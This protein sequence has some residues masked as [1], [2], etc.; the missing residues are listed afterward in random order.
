[1]LGN[2]AKFV[3]FKNPYESVVNANNLIEI[4]NIKAERGNELIELVKNVVE[5]QDYRVFPIIQEDLLE[6]GWKYPQKY[7]NNN[8]RFQK[9]NYEINK[10]GSKYLR[11]PE[12]FYTI[13]K[14]GGDKLINLSS[15]TDIKRGFTTGINDFFYLPSKYYGLIEKKDYYNLIPKIEGIPKDLKIE[16]EFLQ[17]VLKSPKECKSICV[18]PS[19]LKIK[20][21][22]CNK[23][24]NEL[25]NYNVLKYIE[26][27]E[28][29]NFN[30]VPTVRSRR[31][32]WDLGNK[33]NSEIAWIKSVND[34][35]LTP[36][37]KNETL[38]DQ[39][40]YAIMPKNKLENNLLKLLLNSFVLFLFKEIYGRV[41]LGDGVLDTAVYEISKYYILNPK[42]I[43]ELNSINSI[44]REIALREIQSVFE[45]CSINPKKPIREQ[46][47]NPLKD[48]NRLENLIFNELG[49]DDDERKE[50]YWSVCE[51]VKQRLEK[52]K[53]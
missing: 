21:F 51:L 6:D 41:N 31:L 8:D 34:T 33:I 26:W 29:Q 4:E 27:G 23:T 22:V 1:M 32:W 35:H 7:N 47:P 52:A 24:K 19:R 17:S 5:T 53:K 12:I 50:V 20:V 30:N 42:E 11:A 40:L 43:N 49:L 39:R 25:K 45:E 18:D 28:K 48:R 46:E 37:I 16:K 13:L 44:Y 10:W 14:K 38:I 36:T 15:I 3:M 2:V 9:G